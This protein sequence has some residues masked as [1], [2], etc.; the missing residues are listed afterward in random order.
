MR[1]LR[2]PTIGAALEHM[3]DIADHGGAPANLRSLDARRIRP[4]E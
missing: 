4:Q 2:A 3:I 1:A